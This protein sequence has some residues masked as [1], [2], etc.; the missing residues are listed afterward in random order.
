MGPTVVSGVRIRLFRAFAW[1][2]IFGLAVASLAP[3]DVI[4]RTG[5]S[6]KLEHIVAYLIGTASVV[7]AY[8]R[9]KPSIIGG[10]VLLYAGLLEIGQQ[11]VPGRHSQLSDFG[12]SALGILAGLLFATWASSLVHRRSRRHP[13]PHSEAGDRHA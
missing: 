4:I 8:S 13:K 12:A 3:A 2:I 7:L 9:V 6:E 1:A 11:F 10:L 5:F